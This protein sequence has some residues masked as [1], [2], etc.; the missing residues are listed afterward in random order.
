MYVT[1]SQMGGS[2]QTA[3]VGFVTHLLLIESERVITI[4][5]PLTFPRP[6]GSPANM[7]RYN[8]IVVSPS[9]TVTRLIFGDR[10]CS[11]QETCTESRDGVTYNVAIEAIVPSGGL[12]LN[13]WLRTAVLKRWVLLLRDSNGSCYLVSD[14]ARLVMQQTLGAAD[15]TRFSLSSKSWH[16]CWRLQGIEL[17]LLFPEADFDASFDF[18]FNS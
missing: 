12:S 9:T 13:S 8:E 16:S 11:F 6:V 18:S 14:P 17:S 2:E 10:A 4:L 7:V 15:S 5:D 1:E 3:N